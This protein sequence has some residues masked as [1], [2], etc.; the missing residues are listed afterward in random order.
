MS[1]EAQ[2][3]KTGPGALD[4]AQN[5]FGSTKHEN[6]TQ[7]PL[8]RPKIVQERKIR[9][10]DSTPSVLP[11][12]GLGAQNLQMGPDAL[13]S[14]KNESGSAKVENGT[15]HPRYRTKR[16][17]VRKIRKQDPTHSVPP[18]MSSECKI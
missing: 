11:K 5:D 1:P 15:R 13:G 18:Q 9:K 16:V 12:M 3:K 7:R 8:Y 2:N 17:W 14:V 6:G 10:W 4:T